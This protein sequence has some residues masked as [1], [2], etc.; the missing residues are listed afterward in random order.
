LEKK[1]K[2]KKI[3]EKIKNKM[4]SVIKRMVKNRMEEIIGDVKV[5]KMIGEKKDEEY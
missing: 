4:K 5:E 1:I 2:E 3:V